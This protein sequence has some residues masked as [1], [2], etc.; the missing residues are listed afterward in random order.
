MTNKFKA[1]AVAVNGDNTQSVTEDGLDNIRL[2]VF[3]RAKTVTSVC[4]SGTLCT[5]SSHEG[6]EGAPFGSFVD[7]VLDDH[8]N[9]VLLMNEM[10]MHTI[11]IQQ[12]ALSGNK[13]GSSLVTLF[14]QLASD[15]SESKKLGMSIPLRVFRRI[16]LCAVISTAGEFPQHNI[17]YS[18]ITSLRVAKNVAHLIGGKAVMSLSLRSQVS[19]FAVLLTRKDIGVK[20][21]WTLQ[22]RNSTDCTRAAWSLVTKLSY[23]TSLLL[24]LETA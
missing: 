14:T 1:T 19:N 4:T 7:Y 17:Y 24:L 2:N 13:G 11:N 8:G 21:D 9:P 23:L 10:S 3:E 5:V 20:I 22:V 15:T 6:I 18:F 16:V 12:N